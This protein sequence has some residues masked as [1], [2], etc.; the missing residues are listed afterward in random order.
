MNVSDLATL[1]HDAVVDLFT[2]DLNPIGVDQ[3]FYFCNY[4]NPD[5]SNLSWGGQEYETFPIKIEGEGALSTGD[6]PRPRLTIGNI[7]V[8]N[9]I[10]SYLRQY[11][12]LADARVTRHTTYKKHLDGQE[13][14]NGNASFPMGLY[15]VAQKT[16]ESKLEIILELEP[17]GFGNAEIPKRKLTYGCSWTYRSVECEYNGAPVANA[18]DTPLVELQITGLIVNSDRTVNGSVNTFSGVA[19]GDNVVGVGIPASTKI[20]FINGNASQITLSKIPTPGTNVRLYF[21]KDVCGKRS[22]STGTS[23]SCKIRHGQDFDVVVTAGSDT[24]T[25]P[26][27]EPAFFDGLLGA[28]VHT[29]DINAGLPVARRIVE[30]RSSTAIAI[31]SLVYFSDTVDPPPST[32]TFENAPTS[33]TR[34][35]YLITTATAHGFTVGD[36]VC[37]EGFAIQ[38]INGRYTLTADDLNANSNQFYVLATNRVIET[39]TVN[40]A[41]ANIRVGWPHGLTTGASIIIRGTNAPTLNVLKTVTVTDELTFTVP[42]VETSYASRIRSSYQGGY[43]QPLALQSM[44]GVK[45]RNGEGIFIYIPS[46]SGATAC[47]I[48]DSAKLNA[49]VY[50]WAVSGTYTLTIGGDRTYSPNG[51]PFGG[52]P[53]VQLRAN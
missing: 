46:H 27:G 40:G 17:L 15:Q 10:A 43:L 42:H 29:T 30:V 2:I 11:D 39:L 7:L 52:A 41:I 18:D 35:R 32:D 14:P 34:H 5:G 51:L 45:A 38:S 8:S 19:V 21:A 47:R 26:A 31:S 48:G 44:S 9:V 12:D 36:V 23:G 6:P 33:T 28:F 25:I 53:G 50:P 16:S 49:P 24:L 20:L 1:S 37:L 3:V 13:S 4:G 22:G